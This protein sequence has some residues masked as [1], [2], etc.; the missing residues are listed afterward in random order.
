MA[1]LCVLLFLDIPL[2]PSPVSLFLSRGDLLEVIITIASGF[3][4]IYSHNNT[5]RE[6]TD[7]IGVMYYPARESSFIMTSNRDSCPRRRRP[8]LFN[9]HVHTTSYIS[10]SLFPLPPVQPL[11][12]QNPWCSPACKFVAH[13]DK[14]WR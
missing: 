14:L 12:S 10:L 6:T 9:T 13:Y 5:E 11:L 8:F 7:S 4:A 1:P 3:I 2:P